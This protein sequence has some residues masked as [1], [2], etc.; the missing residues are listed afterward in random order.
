[1]G[2]L[3]RFRKKIDHD[4]EK[5]YSSKKNKGFIFK[6]R[7][8]KY[9]DDL[10]HSGAK[11]IILDED[12]ITGKDLY[13]WGINID[14]DDIS[15]DG[16]GFSIDALSKTPIFKITGNNVT[17]KN[18][19]FKNGFAVN[20]GGCIYNEGDSLII[21]NCTF[22]NNQADYGGTIYN[23][24]DINIINCNFIKNNGSGGIV[25]SK[26]IMNFSNCNF[27]NNHV[28]NH[29][30]FRGADG[31]STFENCKFKGNYITSVQDNS[32]LFYN[33]SN[34]KFKNCIFENNFNNDYQEK[35]SLFNNRGFL[36]LIHCKFFDILDSSNKLNLVNNNSSLFIKNS[37]FETKIFNNFVNNGFLDI[38]GC[39][40]DESIKI[41]NQLTGDIY[42]N[43][44]DIIKNI[45]VDD[46]GVFHS[47]CDYKSFSSLSELINGDSNKIILD[48]D[49]IFLPSDEEFLERGIQIDRDDLII[50]GNNFSINGVNKSPIFRNYGKNNLIKNVNFINGFTNSDGG[51]ISNRDNLNVEN[52]SFKGNSSHLKSIYDSSSPFGGFGGAIS[53]FGYLTLKNCNFQNNNSNKYGGA[54]ANCIDNSFLIC[55]DSSFKNNSSLNGGAISNK[56]QVQIVKSEFNGNIADENG[57][58]LFQEEKNSNF[59]AEYSSFLFNYKI[60]N[61]IIHIE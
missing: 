11:E 35:Y 18:I 9:L 58:V 6:K 37:N 22:E 17:L 50:D 36:F 28:D 39:T 55:S 61:N 7:N 33:F 23:E 10:I 24:G 32:A 45:I 49:Y 19:N 31:F 8:F 48:G 27:E 44:E 30:L 2:L 12:I 40:F 16:N 29:G 56:S 43:D 1:M 54:I 59:V 15:I 52:C 21:E 41:L 20:G 5:N 25:L 47:H 38:N 4:K 53:N 34:I 3:D 42:S 51:A 60:N 57:S 13:F 26:G 46:G 14:V